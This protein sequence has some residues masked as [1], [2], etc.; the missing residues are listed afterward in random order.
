MNENTLIVVSAYAGDQHQVDALYP[1][2]RHHGCPVLILSPTDAPITALS[3][4][5]EGVYYHQLGRAEWAGEKALERHKLFLAHLAVLPYD[6]FLFND[7]DSCCLSARLPD[8]LWD[9]SCWSNEVADTNS[10]PSKLPKIAMQPP[11]AFTKSVVQRMLPILD[12]PAMS[13]STV[14]AEGELPVPTHCPDHL[15]LQ[16]CHAAF[17]HHKNFRHGVSWE[18]KSELG[19]HEMSRRV[20]EGTIFCHSVKSADRLHRLMA[21]RMLYIQQHS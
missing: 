9:G 7:A 17:V 10:A 15:Q 8:E 14:T 18:T 6:R 2:Y 3:G 21:A 4:N 12:K 1:V 5:P 13:Y 19:I 11:Y 16:L 20:R